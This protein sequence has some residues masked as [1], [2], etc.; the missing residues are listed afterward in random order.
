MTNR[1]A[2]KANLLA[3][4]KLD[5]ALFFLLFAPFGFEEQWVSAVGH[6]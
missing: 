3:T 2:L 4:C 6:H 1:A 5:T